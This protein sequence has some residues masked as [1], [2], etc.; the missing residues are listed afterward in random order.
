M[1][2]R[3]E[4]HWPGRWE[5][6][7]LVAQHMNALELRHPDESFDAVFSSSSIEHFGDADAV[8]RSMSE[9][10]RVLRPGGVLALATELRLAGPAPGVPHTMMFDAVD[11]RTLLVGALD[12][13]LLGPLD[14]EVDAATRATVVPAEEHVA[15]IKEHFAREGRWLLHRL[16]FSRYPQVVLS[17]GDHVWTSVHLVLRK[18]GR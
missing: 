13:E 9:A 7:R 18:P 12:W 4:I 15:E 10:H 17:L 11:I 14:L 1:L 6:R 16:R 2:E 5:P 3:P 8:R